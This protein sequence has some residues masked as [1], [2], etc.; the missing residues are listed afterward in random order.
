MSDF[1][2]FNLNVEEMNFHETT[3]AK[4]VLYSPSY[5]DGKDNTYSA[6]VRFIPYPKDP[7]NKSILQ[8]YT[9]W[10][11]AGNIGVRG[12][13]DSP[14]TIGKECPLAKT[15]WKLKNSDSAVDQKNAERL[16]RKEQFHSLVW[17]IKDPQN[18]ELEGS[19]MVLRYNKTIKALIDEE[20]NPDP[21]LGV[22]EPVNVF[23]LFRGKDFIIKITKKGDYPD[24]GGCKFSPK[25]T[26]ITIDGKQVKPD[27]AGKKLIKERVLDTAPDLLQYDYQELSQ[28]QQGQVHAFIASIANDSSHMSAIN[29]NVNAPAS[30]APVPDVNPI[31]ED[32]PF[33]EES[34]QEVSDDST[35]DN[36]LDSFLDDL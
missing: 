3:V 22:S 2:I 9:Y 6:V 33:V 20:K 12:Y 27:A 4:K 32:E 29:G 1:D 16:K 15:Y 11:D 13:Y 31:V 24:Y 23:D 34:S 19:V 28:D 7:I 21:E 8:K 10:L 26:S 14:S 36:E 35:V 17:I 25:V 30:N 5:K 18:P